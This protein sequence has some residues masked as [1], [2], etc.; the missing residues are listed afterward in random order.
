MV[1]EKKTI[2]SSKK[3]KELTTF[4]DPLI[5]LLH[6]SNLNKDKELTDT[7]CEYIDEISDNQIKQWCIDSLT[8]L[9]DLEKIE[10]QL[11]QWEF[12]TLDFTLEKG[13]GNDDKMLKNLANRVLEKSTNLRNLLSNER[14]NINL[15]I[16]RSRNVSKNVIKVISDAGTILIELTMRIVKLGKSLDQKVTIGY[17]RAKLTI[18]G[19]ELKKLVTLDPT[20]IDKE[21]VTNYT[22]FV[23][24]LLNQ[25]NMAVA[26]NDTVGLWES[27]AIIGDVEKM[28]ETMKQTTSIA[29]QKEKTNNNNNNNNNNHNV[30]K[31]DKDLDKDNSSS[32]SEKNIKSESNSSDNSN[33][34]T[35]LVDSEPTQSNGELNKEKSTTLS[36]ISAKDLFSN[37]TDLMRTKVTQHI[38]ELMQAFNKKEPIKQKVKKAKDEENIKQVP[39]IHEKS[40]GQDKSTLHDKPIEKNVTTVEVDD[41]ISDTISSVDASNGGYFPYFKPSILSSFY[42]PQMKEPIYINKK[43]LPGKTQENHNPQKQI[44]N[45]EGKQLTN[46][47][48][49]VR[50]DQ[51]SFDDQ[52]KKDLLDREKGLRNK[53]TVMDSQLLNGKS[54]IQRQISTSPLLQ[55]LVSSQSSILASALVPK[56]TKK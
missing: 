53:E 48:I 41:S 1:S 31:A 3:N 35:T 51:M 24:N 43:D 52:A 37:D 49:A 2:T 36:K 12:H 45:G 20:I 38:P 46:A 5:S 14:D 21:I 16:E 17:S 42:Q 56:K 22:T 44:Q 28:F 19:S 9:R 34:D 6:S 10:I 18:I 25:L 30:N 11:D 15:S 23:D 55:Q 7:L 50:L 40:T 29:Q 26:H 54:N 33:T 8:L 4:A 13:I 32:L 47:T 27:V 39:I